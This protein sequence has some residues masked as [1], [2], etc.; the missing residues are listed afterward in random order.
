MLKKYENKY[1]QFVKYFE[2]LINEDKLSHAFLVECR[3]NKDYME[4]ILEFIKDIV[5]KYK[6][7]AEENTDYLIDTNNYPEL[8]YIM[9]INN[10][11]RKEQL[12]NL[13][14][15]FSIKPIYGKYLIYIIDGAEC[16]NTSSANTILKFLEEPNENIIAILLTNNLYNVIETISSRCQKILLP[17]TNDDKETANDVKELFQ[18]IENRT[19]NALGYIDPSWYSLDKEQLTLKLKQLQ[20][21]YIK[22]FEEKKDIPEELDQIS[23]KII[24]IDECL[25]KLRYNVNIKLLIDC[26]IIRIT[27]VI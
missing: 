5:N 18:V 12:L 3:N 26:F 8:K 21:I 9:P 23:K 20:G 22:Y 25:N 7:N 4:I 1:P 27:E 16:L 15:D 10:I 19:N 2:K 11:I 17:S 14:K 6:Y 13:Q 24:V